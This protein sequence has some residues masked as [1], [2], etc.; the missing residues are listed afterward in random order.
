MRE[1]KFEAVSATESA[2]SEEKKAG[3]RKKQ[4]HGSEHQISGAL[5]SGYATGRNGKR[6]A[7]GCH[8]RIAR[9]GRQ[10]CGGGV[11]VV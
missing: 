8:I 2:V 11:V 6:A 3:K 7:D 1:E 4:S 10:R 5:C 9:G